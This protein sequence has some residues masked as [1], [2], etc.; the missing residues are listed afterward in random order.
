MLVYQRVILEYLRSSR[1]DE[2]RELQPPLFLSMAPLRLGHLHPPK[3]IAREHSNTTKQWE[4]WVLGEP[5]QE[6]NSSF[7]SLVLLII[8]HSDMTVI[9]DRQI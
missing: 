1:R 4:Q 9:T 5:G 2:H 3:S 7:D 6:Q 8:T